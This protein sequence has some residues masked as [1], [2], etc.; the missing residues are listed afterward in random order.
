M[1][2]SL[3]RFDVL[4]ADV[5]VAWAVAGQEDDRSLSEEERARRDAFG[6]PDRRLQFTLGRTVARALAGRRLG[7]APHAVPLRLGADGAPEVG[8]LSLSIAHGGRGAE[9]VAAAAAASRPVGV[10]VEAVVPRRPDLWTRIL[11]PAERPL[12][13]ALGGPTDAAQTLL[14][15]LKEAVLKGQRTGLRAGGRSVRLTLDADG[16]PEAGAA[17][18]VSER[19]GRWALRFRRVGGVWLTVAWAERYPKQTA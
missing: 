9:T 15:S 8:G 7:V 13:D 16:V 3:L 2:V 5:E 19:S 1:T 12:L 14:W 10:D 18:A 4:P 6:H 11:V 17:E